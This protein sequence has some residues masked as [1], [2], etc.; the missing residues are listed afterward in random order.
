MLQ[1]RLIKFVFCCSFLCLVFNAQA[2][3][4]EDRGLKIAE[5]M[6][7]RDHGFESFSAKMTMTLTDR[8]GKTSTRKINTKTLEVPGDGDKSL[9][10]FIKPK[11]VRGTK[12][13]IYS[14]KSEADQQW[15]YLPALKRVKRIGS[16]NRTGSFMGSE[17]S[18]ED[19]GSQEVE[20]YTYK[21]IS[22]KKCSKK[23]KKQCFINER[24]PIEKNSGY[25]H[26]VMWIDAVRYIPLKIVYYDRKG[27]KL[28]S[29]ILQKYKKYA[30]KHWRAG[31]MLM[32]NHQTGKK[33]RL[34]FQKYKFRAGFKEGDFDDRKLKK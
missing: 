15:L 8:N 28:K 23:S 21:F 26:H 14:H 7:Q 30:G 25:H 12:M 1:Q 20:R 16:S 4:A 31:V 3:S 32:V 33:T 24:Y 13:L 11:D 5:E 17:F 29:L 2:G 34:D 19:L 18:Y 22:E 9:M 10:E 27:E 6:D